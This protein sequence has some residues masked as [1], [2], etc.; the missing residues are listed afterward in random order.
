MT[1]LIAIFD[2]ERPYDAEERWDFWQKQHVPWAKEKLSGLIK[3]YRT[4]MAVNPDQDTEPV[5][6]MAELWFDSLDDAKKGLSILSTERQPGW[7]SK[8]RIRV[9]VIREK[10]QEL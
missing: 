5:F 1:R 3:R 9:F 4:S 6:G 10:E 2:L 8:R 7:E